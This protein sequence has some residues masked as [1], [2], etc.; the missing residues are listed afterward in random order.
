MALRYTLKENVIWPA[1]WY[2]GTIQSVE[3]VPGKFDAPSVRIVIALEHDGEQR[4]QWAHCSLPT[5]RRHKGYLWYQQI[6]GEVPEDEV[7]M[8]NILGLDTEAFLEVGIKEDGTETNRVVS[9]R[10]PRPKAAA[11]DALFDNE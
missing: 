5:S 10:R 9:F 2:R 7:V 3:E 4:D 8:D 6:T 11:N 1:G